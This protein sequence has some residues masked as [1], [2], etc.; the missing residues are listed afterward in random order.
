MKLNE[1]TNSHAEIEAILK[2]YKIKNYAIHPDGTVDVTG[3]VSFVRLDISELPIKFGHV[4][5][6]F[7]VDSCENITSLAGAPERVDGDFYFVKCTSITS[8]EGSP[9]FVGGD[10]ECYGNT[11]LVTLVGAPPTAG[12]NFDCSGCSQLSSL[13]GAPTTVNGYLSFENTQITSLI[14]FNIKVCK[15]V[16][17]GDPRIFCSWQNIKTGGIALMLQRIILVDR[18]GDSRLSE[19][20]K[21]ITK[22]KDRSDDIFECQAELI[23][24]GYEAYAQL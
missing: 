14:G 6:D 21:I 7:V 23:A 3:D 12:G 10:F 17:S 16:G 13:A 19:P 11:G 5:G 20:F 15:R 8:L 4:A 9:S 2:K 24:A 18:P 22:Y 1:M